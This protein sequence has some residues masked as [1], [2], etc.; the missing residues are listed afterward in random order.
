MS[1]MPEPVDV[2]T[3]ATDRRK[4]VESAMA[5]WC[6]AFASGQVTALCHLGI[7]P[8]LAEPMARASVG[9]MLED[10]A[11]RL[12]LENTLATILAGNKPETIYMKRAV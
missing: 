5:I 10:P 1:Q 2:M 11:V 8:V 9:T 7:P 6:S 12:T 4:L 3:G